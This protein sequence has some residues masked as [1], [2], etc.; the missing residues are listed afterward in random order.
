MPPQARIANGK[1]G[2]PKHHQGSAAF[3]ATAEAAGIKVRQSHAARRRQQKAS[4]STATASAYHQYRCLLKP[5][6][7]EEIAKE[8]MRTLPSDWNTQKP[9]K[10]RPKGFIKTLATEYHCTKGCIKTIDAE[11]KE[12]CRKRE[13]WRK[14]AAEMRKAG[15]DPGKP[16]STSV[17]KT[18]KNRKATTKKYSKE[19]LGHLKKANED[20]DGDATLSGLQRRM[21]VLGT[22]VSLATISVWLIMCGAFLCRRWVIPKIT[23]IHAFNRVDWVLDDLDDQNQLPDMYDRIHIDEKWFF[24]R[25]NGAWQRFLPGDPPPKKMRMT[26]K[27]HI[28]KIMVLT[29]VAR[30][31]SPIGGSKRAKEF[32]GKIGQ[33]RIAI[34]DE[35]KKGKNKGKK[36]F[37][38]ITL[39]ACDWE[40][41]AKNGSPRRVIPGF[42]SFV[43][44]KIIPDIKAKMP[45]MRRRKLFVQMDGAPCHA[46]K[47]TPEWLNRAN[48]PAKADGW[49][50]TFIVQPPRSPD[51]NILDL[52]FF[53]PVQKFLRSTFSD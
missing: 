9:K 53:R 20:S 41:E 47:G 31:F 48:G 39:R 23:H 36:Y 30:P 38:D 28:S 17:K 12:K 21:R 2:A 10:R 7:R 15:K 35:Y 44:H 24:K 42:R 27:S 51:L 34:Q 22:I 5:E 4:S 1:Y 6:D 14:E 26:K 45:W 18:R 3:L 37:R 46:G 13:A 33:Y 16:P 49:D 50:I 52:C 29:V 25:N 43:E 8:L 32:D 19:A 40:M 11:V